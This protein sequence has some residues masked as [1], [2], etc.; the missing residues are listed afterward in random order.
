[1]GCTNPTSRYGHAEVVRLL[2]QEKN[3]QPDELDANNGRTALS[4]AAGNGQEGVVRL[5]L[6]RQFIN[7][8]SV[9]R[10]WG[11]S[12]RVVNHLFGER[13]VNPNSSSKYGRTPL[14]WAV[15]N[16]HEGIVKLLLGRNDVNPDIPDTGYGRTP[17]SLAAERGHDGI[18]K[19]LLERKDVNPDA[20]D[21]KYGRTLL[22]WAAVKVHEGI[23]KLLL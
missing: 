21:M 2:L 16:G 1:M 17:L 15:E 8:G 22:S 23:E 20:P 3:L 6:A 10:Q 14:F 9:G 12:A 13:Y 18:V 7:P 19:L 4:W 11:K 5:F